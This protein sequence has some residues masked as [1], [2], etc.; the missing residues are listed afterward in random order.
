M[1]IKFYNLLPKISM[2]I[3]ILVYLNFT[4]KNIHIAKIAYKI[5]S[6]II[7]KKM[8]TSLSTYKF[9]FLL[10]SHILNFSKKDSIICT[11]IC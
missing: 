5:I 1:F 2:T 3:Y 7:S 8:Y 10:Y 6:T 4:Q 9:G 11:H